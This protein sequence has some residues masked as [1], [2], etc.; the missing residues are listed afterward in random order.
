MSAVPS[1][2]T[3]HSNFASVFNAALETYKQKTTNDLASHP[4]LPSLQSCDSPEAV[5]AVLRE[6]I[7]VFSQSQNGDDRFTKWVAPTVNVL[8]AFSSTLGQGVGLAFPPANV[9]FAGIGVLLLGLQAAKDTGARQDK[10]I[11]IFNR[12]DRFFHR[13]EIYIGV[14]PTMAMTDIVIEIMVEVLTIL[15]IA[16]KE[17]KRGRLKKYLKRLTGNTDIE[18]SL[19]R[20]DKLTQEEARMASA[21]LLKMTHSVDDGVKGVDDR[22]KGVD[23]KVQDVHSDVQGVRGDMQHLGNK[24]QDIDDR[25]QTIGSNV[26]NKLDQVNRSLLL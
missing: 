16:T 26:D 8:C 1:T 2:S 9:V 24:V 7:P 5:L 22:V 15:G 25:V 12:I 18:D 4:L 20:L 14:T 21:E 10:L 3:S 23:G 19:N 6:Q 17:V 13:L 11:E